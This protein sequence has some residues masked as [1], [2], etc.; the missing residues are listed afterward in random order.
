[1]YYH[2]GAQHLMRVKGVCVGVFEIIEIIK[3][4]LYSCLYE[5]CC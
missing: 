5:P 4:G 3:T 2:P 1:M